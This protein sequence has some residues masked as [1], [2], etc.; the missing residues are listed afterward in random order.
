MGRLS[1]ARHCQDKVQR[2]RPLTEPLG[3]PISDF[4]RGSLDGSRG[5]FPGNSGALH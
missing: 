1:G 5:G 2:G 3:K 4:L